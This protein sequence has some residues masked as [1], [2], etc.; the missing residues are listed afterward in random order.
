MREAHLNPEIMRQ[1]KLAY[2]T[3]QL[4]VVLRSQNRGNLINTPTGISGWPE[5][6]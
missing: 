3:N 6:L 2:G 1:E 4:P 5:A